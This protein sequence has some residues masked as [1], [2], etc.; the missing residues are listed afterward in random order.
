MGDD[1]TP[2]PFVSHDRLFAILNALAQRAEAPEIDVMRD[3]LHRHRR[4]TK[5]K[6]ETTCAR[7][8]ALL[9]ELDWAYPE[10]F[11]ALSPTP[12]DPEEDNG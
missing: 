11:R 6:D 9:D 8:L 12:A 7:L 5:D 3:L 2:P 10:A 1:R 4:A